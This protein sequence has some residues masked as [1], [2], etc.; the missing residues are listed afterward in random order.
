MIISAGTSSAAATPSTIPAHMTPRPTVS[1][2]YSAMNVIAV[3]FVAWNSTNAPMITTV[4]VRLPG[5]S[6]CGERAGSGAS[7]A[8]ERCC[9]IITAVITMFTTAI[10]TSASRIPRA[11]AQ[12]M[13]AVASGGPPIQAAEMIA[14]VSTIV[15]VAAPTSRR[16]ANS[17]VVPSPAGP[18]R[19][20]SATVASGSV[21]TA[22][23]AAAS[24]IVSTA[25]AISIGR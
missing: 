3:A 12:P 8:A 22:A 24:A 16:W 4:A 11:P 21:L 18:P 25:A 13:I 5:G 17:I 15:E 9:R 7:A 23:S 19:T 1:V 14:R 2:T 20:T 6:A 10:T